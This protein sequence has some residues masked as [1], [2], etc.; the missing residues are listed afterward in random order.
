MSRLE[1]E[2]LYRFLAYYSFYITYNLNRG[3]WMQWF[4][5]VQRVTAKSS[6]IRTAIL[7]YYILFNLMFL[8]EVEK[9]GIEA[10]V[11]LSCN[12]REYL[13]LHVSSC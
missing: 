13:L 12:T 5:R 1:R 9:L 2:T 10:T 4:E 3:L 11:R 8:L 7:R 6:D